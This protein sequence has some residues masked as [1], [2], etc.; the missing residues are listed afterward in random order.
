[1]EVPGAPVIPLVRLE[2]VVELSTRP[3]PLRG[4]EPELFGAPELS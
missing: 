4:D 1:L 3:P 2:P